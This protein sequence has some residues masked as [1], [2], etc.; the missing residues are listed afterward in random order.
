[1]R[2][3]KVAT[4]YAEALLKTAKE[5]GVL[6]EVA[7][8]FAGV[9]EAVRGNRDLRTFM[10][11]PQVRTE[12]KK[13]L[14]GKVFGDRI[15]PVLLNFFYLLIDRN[16]IENTRD[17]AEVFAELVEADQGVVRA[18]VVTAIGL[19]GDLADRLRGK[20]EG[21]TGMK[22]ILEPRVDPAVIGGVKVTLGDKI[23]DGTVRTNLDLLKKTL[24]EAQVRL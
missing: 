15:E 9:A 8:S 21:L 10:E 20:L 17:I 11:S 13:A 1:M 22:V 12:E 4:R 5:G 3:R 7:E 19:P 16:R 6:I 14:L 23:L 24:G 18:R 2:D